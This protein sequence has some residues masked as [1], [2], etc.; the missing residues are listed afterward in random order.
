[1]KSNEIEKANKKHLKVFE[2]W[3][4]DSGLASKTIDNHVTNVEFYINDFLCGYF[5][6]DVTQGCYE[7]D[8]FLG[9]WFIRKAMW[10]S[11][12]HIKG[13][14]ASLKKFYACMLENGVVE[15][16]DYDALC[17]SIKEN[18]PTWLDEMKRYEV[19]DDSDFFD[20]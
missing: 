10:S 6:K 9:D 17:E 20:L 19:M 8:R 15:Q 12:P 2:K 4:Q 1:M 16:K 5:E 18:M 14:A 11:C 3:L 7:I 13:N